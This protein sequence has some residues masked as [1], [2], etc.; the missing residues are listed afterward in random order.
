MGEYRVPF[1]LNNVHPDEDPGVD[2]QLNLLRALA[3]QETITYNTLTGFL[4]ESVD[5]STMFA[6][7][8]IDLAS[9]DWAPRSSPPT[10]RATSRTTPVSTTPASSTPSART[11]R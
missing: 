3:T 9:P 2:A 1:F 4:D 10:P 8:V 5:I 7:D 6:P 11:S